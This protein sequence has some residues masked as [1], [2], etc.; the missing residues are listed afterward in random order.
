MEPSLLNSYES[1]A[2]QLGYLTISQ[3]LS[4]WMNSN[5]SSELVVNMHIFTVLPFGKTFKMRESSITKKYQGKRE[6]TLN[7]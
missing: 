2:L 4:R 5:K 7:I 6:R 1:K 3:K